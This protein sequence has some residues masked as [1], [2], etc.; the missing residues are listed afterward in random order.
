M[1]TILSQ[2]LTRRSCS[3]GQWKA[4]QLIKGFLPQYEEESGKYSI[5]GYDG[6]EVHLCEIWTGIVPASVEVTY[7]QSQNDADKADFETNFKPTANKTLEMKALDG[8]PIVKTSVGVPGNLFR[9]RPFSFSTCN[10]TS[11]HNHKPCGTAYSDVTIKEYDVDNVELTSDYST[12]VRT[13]VDFE[14]VTDYELIGGWMETEDSLHSTTPGTWY[15]SAYGAPDIPAQ[16]GGC[17]DFVSEADLSLL[18][19]HAIEMDGRAT[20]FIK[21]DPTY[22]SGKIRFTIKHPAGSI[23]WFQIFLEI[24]K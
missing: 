5:W 3:W 18:S 23:K 7:S 8:R 21:Y 16:Y 4:V 17:I 22:H 15:L 10:P 19:D 12:S 24:F 14:A 6:P 2:N 9:L 1:S 20:S 13:V 11:L